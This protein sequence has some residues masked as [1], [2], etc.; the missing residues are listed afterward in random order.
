MLSSGM[1][2]CNTTNKTKLS[3]E[4]KIPEEQF[5]CQRWFW[6]KS[7]LRLLLSAGYHRDY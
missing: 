1:R 4:Y 5:L 7:Y 2:R 3:N 6:L